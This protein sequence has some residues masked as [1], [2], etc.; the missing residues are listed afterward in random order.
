MTSMIARLIEWGPLVV[1][2]VWGIMWVVVTIAGLKELFGNAYDESVHSKHADWIRHVQPPPPDPFPSSPKIQWA[3]GVLGGLLS[4]GIMAVLGVVAIW[5]IVLSYYLGYPVDP[6]PIL[7]GVVS[8]GV[9]SVFIFVPK[10][11]RQLLLA[12]GWGK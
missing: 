10:I 9:V 7:A 1:Q 12:V 6:K 5:G 8:L 11:E 4:L 3:A 2:Q